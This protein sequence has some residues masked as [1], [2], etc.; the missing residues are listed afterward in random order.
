[1]T[2]ASAGRFFEIQHQLDAY[3]SPWH[4]GVDMTM[5][6]HT[7][8]RSHDEYANDSRM[9]I[10]TRAKAPEDEDE[11]ESSIAGDQD[12]SV[13]KEHD[14]V[15][16]GWQQVETSRSK[17]RKRPAM[18]DKGNYPSISHSS[19]SRLQGH[20]RLD[21]LQNLV[22]YLLAD[23]KS[24]QWCSV[25][26]HSNVRKVVLLMV[27]GLEPR[28]FKGKISFPEHSTLEDGVQ[29]G[30][31]A[32]SAGSLEP[33][34]NCNNDINSNTSEFSSFQPVNHRKSS[35][36]PDDYYPTRLE[37]ERLPAPLKPLS[38]MFE[39]MW[40]IRAP[41]DSKYSRMHSPLAALLI[42]P[43]VKSDKQKKSKGPQPPAEGK[44]WTDE[45]TLI[46]EFLATSQEL[47]DQGYVV[48]PAHYIDT[49][50]ATEQ[51]AKR[52]PGEPTIGGWVDTP[53]IANL[54]LAQDKRLDADSGSLTAGKKV[55][56][57]DCEM[58]ITSPPG[59]SPQVFSLTR[60]AIIDWD[61]NVVL[62]EF[63]KPERPI[64]DYL[65][66]YSGITP[67]M[68]ENVST[69]LQDIQKKL[70][71]EILTPET[72]LIGHSLES[73]F[74]A[75]QLTHPY[76]ID[77]SLLFPHPRGPPLKSSLKWLAQKYL[78]REIQKGHGTVGHDSVEDAKACLD[79]VK[80]KCEKGK[81]WGT[82][83][84]SGESIF[85]RLGRSASSEKT[86]ARSNG[87]T[88]GRTGAVVDWGE[89]TRGYGAH[90]KLAIGCENDEQVVAGVKRAVSGVEN[91]TAMSGGGVDFVFGRLRELE[92]YRGW[93]NR[94]KSVDNEAL[95]NTTKSESQSESL[96]TVTAKTIG[97]ISEVWESLPPCTGFIVCSGSGDPRHLSE[98][99]ALQQKF[100]N[101]YK[102]KKWDELS[103][104][105]T[106]T[107]EQK[108]RKACYDARLGV[109]FLTVK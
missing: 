2:L 10:F 18:K 80:Q 19:H 89:P 8:K 93:W 96:S 40:P 54:D 101:E 16:E 75:L 12:I 79:L 24:P 38:D 48:H 37:S 95:R 94:S 71:E 88:E 98:A 7:R 27:P 6:A 44:N 73:D 78:S 92:A 76:I 109:G 84:A 53:G 83:E 25:R 4:R 70:V 36:S 72:I 5:F 77:T 59:V 56:A 102:T 31:L 21:D 28:M 99:Q 9:D 52:T 66:P 41:G 26:H 23:G 15:D 17:K 62:D 69:S 82:A 46:T 58:C 85:K 91:S 97:H 57:I 11:V 51:A 22:L 74:N 60:I 86:K 45:R 14:G 49:A 42:S 34:E 103:V 32:K 104:K 67:A 50:I 68:L 35:A 107:E 39:H 65:T 87:H 106:D 47:L 55:L 108:L 30:R 1:M 61:G 33:A 3:P 64:T 90:A 29:H 105:W 13:L 63:I 43:I 81:A 20:V 100:K